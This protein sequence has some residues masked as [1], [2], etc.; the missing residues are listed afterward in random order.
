MLTKSPPIYVPPNS[1][2]DRSVYKGLYKGV[3]L[4]LRLNYSRD[5]DFDLAVEEYSKAFAIIA[6]NSKMEQ[7]VTFV[8]I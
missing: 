1:C 5:E 6:K 3:G 4:R 8:V 7:N 2:H